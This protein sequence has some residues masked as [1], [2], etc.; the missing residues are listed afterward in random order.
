[1]AHD[2]RWVALLLRLYPRAYRER[3]GD[4]LAAAMRACV[5]RERHAGAPMF[6]TAARLLAD[7]IAASFLLRSGRPSRSGDPIMRS[8]A[9]DI[10]YA[11]RLL[12]RA[13]LFSALSIATLALAIGANTAIFSIVNGVLLRDLPYRDP[14]RLVLMY[15]GILA[16][17]D[18]FGFSPP[19]FVAFRERAR[20][21]DAL[22]AYRNVEYELSGVSQPER[23]VGARV[24]ASLFDVLGITPA[25]GRSFTEDED[26]GRQP[27]A[28][29]SDRLWRRSFGADP[30]IAGKAVTLDRRAFT[31]VGVMPPS[32]TFPTRGPH[33]NNLPADVYVPISFTNSE[34]RA[35]GTMYNNSV[36]G[37]LKN[38]VTVEQATAEAVP[39]ARQVFAEIYPAQLRDL[40]TGIR[41]VVTPM[42]ANVV[43]GVSRILYVLLAAVGVVLL[44]ACA[45]IACL[46]LTR[47]AAREREMAI[48]AALGA[49]RWRVMRLILIETGL[50]AAAGAEPGWR[51]RGGDIVCCSRPRRPASRAQKRSRSTRECCSSRSAPQ[52][53]PRSSA[54]CCRRSS[55]HAGSRGRRSRRVDEDPHRYGSGGSSRRS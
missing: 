21:F 49:G 47:A 13:P 53:P 37:R 29:L 27:V 8:I 52:L 44:I 45:D 32:F 11:F 4:D 28:I 38:G 12:R 42:R 20:S 25:L 50:V 26:R 48:R 1:V 16:D 15:E 24:S 43:G 23:I 39:L 18:P 35:F 22:A 36:V 40:A 33:L 10:R 5:E 3:H 9:G 31:I 6:V 34:L 2:P 17:K 46:T 7:T 41:T 54:A 14:S 55:P 51:S 30:A 19:D